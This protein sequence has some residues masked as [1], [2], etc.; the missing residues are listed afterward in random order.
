[1]CVCAGLVVRD[2]GAVTDTVPRAVRQWQESVESEKSFTVS[3]FELLCSLL[4]CL[5][6]DPPEGTLSR[7]NVPLVCRHDIAPA[8]VVRVG[9]GLHPPDIRA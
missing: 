7:G 2:A 3:R 5:Q 8:L 9:R 6:P 4:G 1:M